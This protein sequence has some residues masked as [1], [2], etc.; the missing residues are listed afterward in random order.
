MKKNLEVSQQESISSYMEDSLHAE[1]LNAF[2][3]G[4]WKRSENILEQL[5]DTYP[6]ENELRQ[7]QQDL[8]LKVAVDE[9][10]QVDVKQDRKDYRKKLLMMIV[11]AG[12]SVLILVVGYDLSSSWLNTKRAL[13]EENFQQLSQNIT[14]NR[15]FSDSQSLVQGERYSQALSLLQDIYRIDP[16]YPNIV[17]SLAEAKALVAIDTVYQEAMS[18]IGQGEG[19]AALE[20]LQEIAVDTPFFKDIEAQIS[21]LEREYILVGLISQ[22]NKAYNDERWINAIEFYEQAFTIDSSLDASGIEER[23]FKSYIRGAEVILTSEELSLEDL[24]L[25]EDYFRKSL[26]LRPQSREALERRADVNESISGLLASGYIR[27]AQSFLVDQADSFAALDAASVYFGKALSLNPDAA[28]IRLQYNLARRYLSAASKFGNGLW[29]DAIEDLEFVVSSDRMYA[30]GTAEQMLYEAYGA[31]GNSF[32]AVGEYEAAL[33]DFEQAVL[34]ARQ[35]PDVSLRLF[36][37][38]I[39][40]AYALGRSGNHRDAVFLY[41]AAIFESGIKRELTEDDEEL[42]NAIFEAERAATRRDYQAAYVW[43]SDALRGNT[44]IFFIYRHTV[45]EGD[46]LAKLAR[47]YNSTIQAIIEANNLIYPYYLLQGQVLLIPSI[48]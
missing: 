25:A 46:Y 14:L 35:D 7:L 38:Q 16:S 12:L 15:K 23:L 26:S 40:I 32:L 34:I 37:A 1:F 41:K 22:G 31:R 17:S 4:E 11:G 24:E 42:K 36:E 21:I 8:Q 6:L 48:K 3:G 10:E 20:I 19:L 2:Q 18:L 39:N 47:Q 44:D 27:A 9:I 5:M 30:A 29:S 13:A 33:D 45:V 43:Y 28:E